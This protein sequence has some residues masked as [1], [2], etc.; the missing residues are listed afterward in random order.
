MNERKIGKTEV[1]SSS[2]ER[3]SFEQS[4]S[5][6][7]GHSLSNPLAAAIVPMH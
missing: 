1:Q 2:E 4:T 3:G 5:K 6:Q 7:A